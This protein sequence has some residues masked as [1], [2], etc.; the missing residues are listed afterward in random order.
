MDYWEQE[1]QYRKLE[2]EYY[3]WEMAQVKPPYG[4]SPIEDIKIKP[5]VKTK[6]LPDSDP[7]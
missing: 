6:V 3:K 2:E 1:R 4:F 7:K 5:L